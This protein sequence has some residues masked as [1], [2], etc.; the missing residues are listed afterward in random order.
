[1]LAKFAFFALLLFA[2][3]GERDDDKL[4]ARAHNQFAVNLLKQLAS[5]EPS[6]NIVFSPT[7]IAAAF[8]MAY[9]GARGSSEAE[10]G[11]VLGHTAVGLTDRAR[12]LAA[13][14]TL[15]QLVASPNVTLDVA[16]LVLAQRGFPITDSYQQQLRDVFDAELRSADFADAGSGAAAEVNAWVRYKTRGKI[17]DILPERESLYIVL[18]ILNAVYF[19]GT[20]VTKFDAADT[21]NRPFFNLGT[22]EVSRPAMHLETRLPHTRLDALNAS[23]VEIP[24]HG[25]KFGMVVVLPDNPTELQAVRNDLSVAVIDALGE[26]MYSKDVV[27]RLPKFE[28]SLRYNLVPAMQA[29]G[30]SVVFGRSADFSRIVDGERVHIS[31]AVHKAALEV[32]E[33]GTIAAAVTGL[34]IRPTS[35]VYIPP[36][37]VLFTVD[38]P[39]LYYIRDNDNNRILFVGEVHRL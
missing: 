21:A 25:G 35:A 6:S 27:L 9:A 29:L 2:V 24:Y 33:E 34:S 28:M 36:P 15:L 5:Q 4:L 23:A 16:N 22:S 3:D 39:F 1:M 17:S 32:N 12:V 19:K 26:T 10:L 38:H 20:W 14:K 7:S 8:G 37:P 13:Y 31:D 18:F 30:L 11:S